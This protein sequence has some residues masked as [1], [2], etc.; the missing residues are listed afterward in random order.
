MVQPQEVVGGHF[1]GP[2]RHQADEFAAGDGAA[3]AL[4]FTPHHAIYQAVGDL[5][6]AFN[7]GKLPNSLDDPRY[8]NIKMMQKVNLQ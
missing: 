2:A 1:Q 6:T 8:F 5:I 7:R 4:G 3:V